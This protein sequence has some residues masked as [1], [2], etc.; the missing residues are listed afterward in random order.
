MEITVAGRIPLVDY[1]ALEPTPHLVAQECTS[2][3]AR[4]FERRTACANCSAVDFAPVDLPGHGEV[5]S[6][7]IVAFAPPGVPAPYVAAVV[8]CG[9]TWVR[10]NLVEVDPDPDKIWLGMK[11]RLATYSLGTD[12][13]GTEGVGFGYA[14]AE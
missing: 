9:G 8:D 4:Y 6:F 11:V 10:A 13:A 5:V 12:S 1:L 3:G 7:T 14:P 2:C